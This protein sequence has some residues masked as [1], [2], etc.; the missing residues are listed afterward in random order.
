MMMETPTQNGHANG[1]ASPESAGRTRQRKAIIVGAGPVGCLAAIALANQGWTVEVYEGRPGAARFS[2]YPHPFVS[3]HFF[4]FPDKRLSKS[5]VGQRSINLVVSSRGLAAIHAIDPFLEERLM[6]HT[7]PIHSR[8]VHMKDGRSS[9]L[10]YDPHNQASPPV[11]KVSRTKTDLY[12]S[13]IWLRRK[14]TINAIS[15]SLLNEKL[16]EE[17]LLVPN[18]R[19]FF[20]HKPQTIDFHRKIINVRDVLEDT[21]KHVEFDLC[22]GADGSHSFVRRQ[23]MRVTR[24]VCVL[25][26]V[27][28]IRCLPRLASAA[29]RRDL[30]EWA[31]PLILVPACYPEWTISKS[32]FPTNIW[33]SG[34]HRPVM[35]RVT[36]RS[37][38]IKITSTYG[39]AIHLCLWDC[40]IRC[41]VFR[42]D[43]YL[44][45]LF[46]NGTLRYLIG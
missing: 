36:Q 2:S 33:S 44:S 42:I 41:A 21:T 35:R 29:N 14:Q 43:Y 13:P 4:F 15:R 10:Q 17:A 30:A 27:G 7:I 6:K 38:L 40:P 18:I 34:C 39:H 24:C 37:L 1:E 32:I 12:P 9:S 11:T 45:P 16:V 22:I 8:M 46:L 19:I 23:M 31:V 3:F 20:E 28:S 26:A 25:C 5:G